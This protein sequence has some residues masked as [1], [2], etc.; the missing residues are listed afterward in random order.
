VSHQD[1]H[2]NFDF[3]K[4]IKGLTP[5][6]LHEIPL[7]TLAATPSLPKEQE[8]YVAMMIED[9]RLFAQAW[10]F[11]PLGRML[12]IV[13]EKAL[14]RHATPCSV[15]GFLMATYADEVHGPIVA[16]FAEE[17]GVMAGAA[18][19]KN[20]IV[21]KPFQGRG[22]GTELSIK[23]YDIGLFHP[24]L[25]NETNYLSE[26]GRK[27]RK[28]AHRVAV[29]RAIDNGLAVRDEVLASYP[30]LREKAL[31]AKTPGQAMLRRVKAALVEANHVDHV[32]SPT[33]QAP[34]QSGMKL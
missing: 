34:D 26:G 25:M 33:E 31:A 20:I 22:I 16:V 3:V 17:T 1:L 9:E 24:D 27:L 2:R 21:R 15:P 6:P 29:E 18:H 32:P 8:K 5:M 7:D 23:A 28:T 14:L 10:P 4:P 11:N 13:E 12:H 30:D 19:W